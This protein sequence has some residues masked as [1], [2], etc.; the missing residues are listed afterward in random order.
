MTD[1]LSIAN[2]PPDQGRAFLVPRGALDVNTSS[3]LRSALFETVDAGGENVVVDLRE[4]TF[5]D[6]A[7]FSALLA[8]SKRL[9]ARGGHLVLITTDESVLRMLR[10]M[11]LTEVMP[12]A[13][14]SE[15]AWATL[16]RM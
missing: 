8:A 4:V 9:G 6:S 7:G 13:A 14:T 11:G 16:A 3:E 12:V 1:P 5:V 15:D 2:E 10:I